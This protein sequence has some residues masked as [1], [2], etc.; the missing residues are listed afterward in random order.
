[1]S[2]RS[3][4][5]LAAV[6]GLLVL[7]HGATAATVGLIS[8]FQS[9]LGC[10]GDF[11]PACPITQL[12]PPVQ[13][14]VW[15]KTL[16]LPTGGWS[17]KVAVDGLSAVYPAGANVPLVLAAARSVSFYYDAVTN[18]VVDNV[19]RFIP[20]LAGDFQSELGCGSDFNPACMRSWLRDEEGTGT[21]TFA[22]LLPVGSYSTVVALNESF[23]EVY[24]AGGAPN[25]ANI[26]FVVSDPLAVTT[27][28]W[29]GTTK[30]LTI[31]TGTPPPAPVPLPASV[32]LLGAALTGLR[33]LRRDRQKQPPRMT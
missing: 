7:P 19:N 5:C 10:A 9:E 32:L 1:M 22:T 31:D 3:W 4:H 12:T 30:I 21:Y 28:T 18:Y 27:F 29:D 8:D 13:D 25:G 17:Y 16:N 24:G 11:D 2:I 33:L 14:T 6:A 23:D 26:N 20:I 15:R